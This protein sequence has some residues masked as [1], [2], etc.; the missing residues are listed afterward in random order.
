LPNYKSRTTSYQAKFVPLRGQA[1]ERLDIK[2][3]KRD[4][5]A[6]GFTVSSGSDWVVPYSLYVIKGVHK[7]PEEDN[8]PKWQ[9]YAIVKG[10][11]VLAKDKSGDLSTFQVQSKRL[12]HAK[13]NEKGL[14]EPRITSTELT[15][16][17]FREEW[18]PKEYVSDR[19]TVNW[20]KLDQW[21]IGD[22]S[23]KYGDV[24][25]LY[26][27]AYRHIPLLLETATFKNSVSVSEVLKV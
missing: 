27:N 6:I 2:D 9:P 8:L 21:E 23:Y 10:N 13:T 20:Y 25:M 5:S 7:G 3:A 22:A 19:L 15:Y 4:L 26:P 14:P 24:N 1:A 17:P 18:R 11:L 16:V 12:M